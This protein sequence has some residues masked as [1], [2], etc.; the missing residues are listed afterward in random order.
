MLTADE[1]ETE[2]FQATSSRKCIKTQKEQ[3]ANY[4]LSMTKHLLKVAKRLTKSLKQN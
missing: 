1:D 4:K 2:M 3:K